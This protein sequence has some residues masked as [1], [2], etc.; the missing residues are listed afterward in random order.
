M[1]LSGEDAQHFV[2]GI[3]EALG[4]IFGH[5]VRPEK[6]A[7]ERNCLIEIIDGWA[8]EGARRKVAA[9]GAGSETVQ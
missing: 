2:W 6:W 7:D 4:L 5:D 9:T 1:P 3:A 8:K